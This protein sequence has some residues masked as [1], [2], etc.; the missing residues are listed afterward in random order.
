MHRISL[1]T[2]TD[3]E[4]VF[5]D[6]ISL[7]NVVRIVRLCFP[8]RISLSNRTDR[9]AVFSDRIS[10]SILDMTGGNF[11]RANNL[12]NLVYGAVK[13]KKCSSWWFWVRGDE[14]GMSY[15]EK[16]PNFNSKSLIEES[17]FTIFKNGGNT[18]KMYV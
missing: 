2:R 16:W 7:S 14:H 10:L 11:K 3:R 17:N 4:A 1:S 13:C 18:L 5:S 9:E 6:R 15:Q 8:D 12:N